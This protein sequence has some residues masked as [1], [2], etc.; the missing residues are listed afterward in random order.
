VL[1]KY[2]AEHQLVTTGVKEKLVK[3]VQKHELNQGL[4]KIQQLSGV[5]STS[6][7]RNGRED[8]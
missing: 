1:K 3:R 7:M 8:F 6:G 2:C 4:L 5:F